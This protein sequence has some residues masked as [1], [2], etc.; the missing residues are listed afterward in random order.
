MQAQE[1]VLPNNTTDTGH[2]T[3]VNPAFTHMFGA[4]PAPTP[5]LGDNCQDVHT[6]TEAV[7]GE[8]G[9]QCSMATCTGLKSFYKTYTIQDKKLHLPAFVVDQLLSDDRVAECRAC[10]PADIPDECTVEVWS[11][12]PFSDAALQETHGEV[13]EKASRPQKKCP[14]KK[15]AAHVALLGAG[16]VAGVLAGRVSRHNYSVQN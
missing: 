1:P 8:Q 12:K 16:L 6:L 3:I 5:I 2:I 10:V 13:M 9:G 4:D 15:K 11:R 14:V 7:P